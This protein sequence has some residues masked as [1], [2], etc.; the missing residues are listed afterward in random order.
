ME[1]RAGVRDGWN[2]R[3]GKGGARRAVAGLALAGAMLG[4]LAGCVDGAGAAQG[5][6]A[7]TQQAI[8]PQPLVT[9]AQDTSLG[10]GEIVYEQGV[11]ALSQEQEA[12]IH[13]YMTRAYEGLGRLEEPDFSDLFTDQTQ[14]QA[15]QSGIALQI[16]ARQL[17]DGLDYTLTGYHYTLSCMQTTQREDGTVEVGAIETVVQNFTQLPGVDSE[18]SGNFH[19]FV[20]EQVEGRWYLQSHMQY[21]TLYGQLMEELESN[22]RE[23]DLAAQYIQAMPAY[24]EQLQAGQAQREAQQGR[25][26]VLPQADHPY[27]RQGALDYADAYAMERNLDWADYSFV[28]GNCQNYVSQCLLAGGIPMDTAGDA[29]WKWYG[30]TPSSS[31][32]AEGRSPSWTGVG[33]FLRYALDN[34]GFGL[35]AQVDAP[36][37]SGQ[38]GDLIQMGTEGVWRHVVIIRALVQDEAGNTVDYLIH[39]NTNDLRNFPA[40]LY[41]YPIFSLT[42]IIGWND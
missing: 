40:S 32:R 11:A 13:A 8:A 10:E 42:R 4:L 24:L 33:S 12:L 1:A 23:V 9:Q 41:C 27:D 7:P 26:S 21:D 15:S 16:G 18:R 28:G 14:A 30:S 6:A 36:Y 5:S 19:H 38:P 20:L 31:T 35:V 22:W 29:V 39:S 17:I 2:T 34:D 37:G 3:T 25:D